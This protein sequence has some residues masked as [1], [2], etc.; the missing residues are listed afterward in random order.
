MAAAR[1]PD[2]VVDL[3]LAASANAKVALNAGIQVHGHGAV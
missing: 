1:H 2:D 3:D